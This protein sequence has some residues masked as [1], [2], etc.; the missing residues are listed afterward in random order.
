MEINQKFYNTIFGIGIGLFISLVVFI[1][2]KQPDD[3][4]QYVLAES[5]E[6]EIILPNADSFKEGDFIKVVSLTRDVDGSV[7]EINLDTISGHKIYVPHQKLLFVEIDI[8]KLT[9][10]TR[11]DKTIHFGYRNVAEINDY[12]S[13]IF[14]HSENH[15]FKIN[16]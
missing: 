6:P 2:M 10:Y 5:S 12:L 3:E 4:K 7:K 8:Q 13:Y 11:I 14:P 15:K 1:I 9:V 16:Q